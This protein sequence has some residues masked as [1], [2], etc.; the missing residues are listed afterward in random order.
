MKAAVPQHFQHGDVI[1]FGAGFF[2]DV[3][4]WGDDDGV[5]GEDEGGFPECGIVYLRG[6]DVEGFAGGRLEGVFEGR[7]GVGEV[8]GQGGGNDFEGGE[9]DLLWEGWRCERG[10]MDG[11]VREYCR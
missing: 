5:G 4:A 7:E 10:G 6:V 1:T 2:E 9:T 11:S 3:A 8:F